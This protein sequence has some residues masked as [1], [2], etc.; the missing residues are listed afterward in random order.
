MLDRTIPVLRIVCERRAF[1][2]DLYTFAKWR[3]AEF[4]TVEKRRDLSVLDHR[5]G[6]LGVS[7][8]FG[9]IFRRKQIENFAHGIWNIH[10]GKLPDIRSRHPISWAFLRADDRF[11]LSIHEID[12]QIDRGHLLAENSI[13]RELHDTE[14]EVQAGLTALL[15]D[16]LFQAAVDNYRAGKKTRLGEGT[17]YESL[18]GKYEVVD[19]AEHDGEF[20]FNLVCSQAFHGGFRIGDRQYRKCVFVNDE[21]IEQ[22]EEYDLFTCR[23][24]VTV[25]LKP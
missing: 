6:S 15:E 11:H 20:L 18:A 9:I 4:H 17:Y 21:F 24:G 5:D 7:C 14:A 10:F 23:D 8:G 22:Y 12:E 19:P 16:G 13:R 2:V 1:N 25:G 3:R